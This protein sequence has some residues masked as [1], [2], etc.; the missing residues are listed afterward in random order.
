MAPNR[1]RLSTTTLRLLFATLIALALQPSVASAQ[2]KAPGPRVGSSIEDF[3][4]PDQHGQN[5]KLSA[6]LADGPIALV[7]LRS[8]GW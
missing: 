2:K 4:L 3:S 5:R 7:V 6:L 1:A 8:A